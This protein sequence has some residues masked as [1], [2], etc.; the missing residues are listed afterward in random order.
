MADLRPLLR[1][2]HASRASRPSAAP[3]GEDAPVSSATRGPVAPVAPVADVTPKPASVCPDTID[4]LGKYHLIAFLARGGMA[5]VYLGVVRGLVG[6]SKLLVI[7][8]LRHDATDDETYVGMFMDEARLAARLN[9]P[10]V[11][12]TVEG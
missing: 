12:Q 7:K 1:S 11:V 10:N 4:Q 8:E 5:D 3:A 6:F 2:S 9:H